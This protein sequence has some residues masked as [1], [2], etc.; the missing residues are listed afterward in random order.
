MGLISLYIVVFSRGKARSGAGKGLQAEDRR[1]LLHHTEFSEVELDRL[2][3]IFKTDYPRGGM[4]RSQFASFFPPG[5]T[6][7]H[8]CDHVF[9]TLDTDGN[10]KFNGTGYL[11]SELKLNSR[12]SGLQ[13]V[14]HGK[15]SHCCEKQGRKTQLGF[16]NV[17]EISILRSQYKAHQ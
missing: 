16:Q 1:W 15:R 10:G 14:H 4:F 17:S 9:R 6:S 7:V 5:L 3:S 2:Y 11:L 13:R 8:F 12:L